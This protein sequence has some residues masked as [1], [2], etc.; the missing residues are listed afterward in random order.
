MPHVA[1]PATDSNLYLEKPGSGIARFYGSDWGR[2]STFPG[3]PLDSV[4]E[5]PLAGREV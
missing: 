3:T 1:P 4:P 2:R 5:W